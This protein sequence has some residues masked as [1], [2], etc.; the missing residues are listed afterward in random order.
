M[1]F[2]I[3]SLAC[4]NL[5]IL[6]LICNLTNVYVQ[7]VFFRMHFVVGAVLGVFCISRLKS[8]QLNLLQS[9]ISAL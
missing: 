4:L 8:H 2:I 7:N 3:L 9:T 1:Y 5:A 6:N